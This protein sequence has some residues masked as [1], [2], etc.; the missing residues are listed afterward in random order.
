MPAG[1]TEVMVPDPDLDTGGGRAALNHPVG[2]LLPHRLA[3]QGAGFAPGSA[4]QGTVRIAGDVGGGD[5]FV[6]IT[7][8]FVMAGNLML[9]QIG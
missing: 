6:E 2:V 1:S 7:Y 4:K 5:V 8:Q 9:T 3:P